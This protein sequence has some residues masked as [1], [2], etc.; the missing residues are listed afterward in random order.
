MGLSVGLH[1]HALA[2][3]ARRRLLRMNAPGRLA[4]MVV[5]RLKAILECFYARGCQPSLAPQRGNKR[6]GAADRVGDAEQA[7]PA[8]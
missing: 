2:P 3:A 7:T 6:T 5:L 1:R 4:Q 8:D